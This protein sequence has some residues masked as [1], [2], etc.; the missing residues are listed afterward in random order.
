MLY[1]FQKNNIY[2]VPEQILTIFTSF[3]GHSLL[4]VKFFICLF[5]YVH[6]CDLF[7]SLGLLE[8]KVKEF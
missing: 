7:P 6:Q 1:P 5:I 3:L 4:F 8:Q 2:S